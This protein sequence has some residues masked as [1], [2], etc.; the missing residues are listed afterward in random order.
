[1]KWLQ[2]ARAIGGMY[3]MALMLG[4]AILAAPMAA[5]ETRAVEI[6]EQWPRVEGWPQGEAVTFGSYAPFSLAEIASGTAPAWEASARFFLPEGASAAD[7]GPAVVLL[8]GAGGVQSAREMAYAAQ[9]AEMGIAALVVDVFGSRRDIATGFVNRLIHITEAAM[10]TDAY[11]ALDWLDAR[12]EV[13]GDR[14]ALIGFSYGGMTTVFAAYEQV[15]KLL[16]GP[17]GPRFAAHIAFYGPCIARFRNVATTGAPVL[18]LAGGRDAIVDQERCRE[19]QDDL[20]RGGSHV[21]NVLYPDG[22]HLW[23]GGF[24]GQRTIGRN[25][26]PC[27][28]EVAPDFTVIDLRSTLPMANTFFRRMILGLCADSEGYMMGSNAELRA[29]SNAE[30]GRFLARAFND[31]S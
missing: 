5:A 10:V 25:L 15:A 22:L 20:R 21:E 4:V 16:S 3:G 12:P 9:F 8:H 28:L 23:D 7:P 31:G 6:P 29:R 18:F 30:M 17:D 26:A 2:G 24:G 13:D 19:I 27:R 14:I 1:M 11:A